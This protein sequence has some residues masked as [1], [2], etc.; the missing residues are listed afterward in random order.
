MWCS[1]DKK[2]EDD[3]ART[4][5]E[6]ALS[7]LPQEEDLILKLQYNAWLKENE[8]RILEM[9]RAMMPPQS[10]IEYLFNSGQIELSE[11]TKYML[12]ETGLYLPKLKTD[13]NK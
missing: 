13:D 11:F 5:M 12:D 8:R 9:R 3:R 1:R 10:M 7:K 4:E 6:L 2:K